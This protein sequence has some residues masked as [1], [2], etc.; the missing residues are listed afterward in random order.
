MTLFVAR[1]AGQFVFFFVPL[2]FFSRSEPLGPLKLP[3]FFAV[4]N[5]FYD[6][7]FRD[8]QRPPWDCLFLYAA[9]T[10]CFRVHFWVRFRQPLAPSGLS[11]WRKVSRVAPYRSTIIIPLR[12]KMEG[13]RTVPCVMLKG[14]LLTFLFV[15]CVVKKVTCDHEG[16]LYISYSVNSNPTLGS[17]QKRVDF[18]ISR[19]VR[20][21]GHTRAIHSTESSLSLL[22]TMFLSERAWYLLGAYYDALFGTKLSV[23]W[24]GQL[25]PR[26]VQYSVH[27]HFNPFGTWLHLDYRVGVFIIV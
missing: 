18:S 13:G 6:S 27:H 20:H 22:P 25:T 8:V 12:P 14:A 5:S 15:V 3:C 23:G 10:K 9:P 19:V 4:S 21:L 2:F 17:S 26:T 1:A 16:S 24:L 11:R 7:W